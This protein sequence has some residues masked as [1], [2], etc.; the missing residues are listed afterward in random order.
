MARWGI[1]S[2]AALLPWFNLRQGPRT[3]SISVSMVAGIDVVAYNG[4]V[5]MAFAHPRMKRAT[6]YSLMVGAPILLIGFALWEGGADPSKLQRGDPES[7]VLKLL[8]RPDQISG[9]PPHILWGRHPVVH[10]VNSGECVR[11]FV[12]DRSQAEGRESWHIG[13]DSQSNVISNYR[14]SFPKGPT[15]TSK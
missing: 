9:P 6:K 15:F 7:R 8:G 13:F 5:C 10:F 3:L 14:L 1:G 12:Y 4:T 11:E 2:G